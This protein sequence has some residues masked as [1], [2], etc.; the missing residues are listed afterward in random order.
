MKIKRRTLAILVIILLVL[1]ALWF[2]RGQ[3]TDAHA[4]LSPQATSSL[5]ELAGE[6]SA[7]SPVQQSD[8]L[9]QQTT[10]ADESAPDESGEYTTKEDI[11]AYL[12]AYGKLPPNFITKSEARALGWSGGG[13]D[14]YDYGKCIGG[15]EFGNN[16][17]LLPDKAGRT[18]YECDV[19]TLHQDDRGA[20]RIVYSGDGLIY[21]TEDHYESFTQLYP[22]P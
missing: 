12:I 3:T 6:D 16:E 18:Y 22:A 13:L 5:V 19:D 2:L 7:A 20:K 8:A 21:Y 1:A 11:A 17:G 14:D 15:D 4:P 10:Y 9:P